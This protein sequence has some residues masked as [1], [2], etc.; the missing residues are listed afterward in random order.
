MSAACKLRHI[1]PRDDFLGELAT[2]ILPSITQNLFGAKFYDQKAG[3]KSLFLILKN[4]YFSI[5]RNILYIQYVGYV[6]LS[7]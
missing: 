4:F 2:L 1:E 5:H 3:G 6:F 7:L